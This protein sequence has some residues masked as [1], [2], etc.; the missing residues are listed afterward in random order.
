LKTSEKND[1]VWTLKRWLSQPELTLGTIILLVFLV[2]CSLQ[3]ITRYVFNE[4]LVWTEE[5]ASNLLIWLTFLGAAAVQRQDGHVRVE[6][7]EEILSPSVIRWVY[8][9]YDVIVLVWLVYAVVGGYQLFFEMEFQKTPALRIPFNMILSIVPIASAIMI[10]Y[11]LIN[12]F[13][14]FRPRGEA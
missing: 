10:V 13:R 4:P 2:L 12:V 11:V 3:V 8:S 1:D 7:I 9:A 14:R 5:L 6:I